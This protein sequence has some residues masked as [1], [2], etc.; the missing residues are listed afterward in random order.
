MGHFNNEWLFMMNETQVNK[1]NVHVQCF[2]TFLVESYMAYMDTLMQK[3]KILAKYYPHHATN[4]IQNKPN[5]CVL[6]L[7]QETKDK[8]RKMF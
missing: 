3:Q 4:P 5:T 1:D 8:I 2:R 6:D 7:L